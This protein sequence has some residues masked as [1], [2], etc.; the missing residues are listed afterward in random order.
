MPRTKTSFKKGD[1]RAGRPK[2]C[3]N[4]MTRH[5][6]DINQD[7]LDCFTKDDVKSVYENLKEKNPAALVTYIAKILP[8][9]INVTHEVKPDNP[10]LKAMKEAR[11]RK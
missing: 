4:K 2:G 5:L 11:E 8:K 6:K 7:L 10:I 3:Q 1:P 9:D